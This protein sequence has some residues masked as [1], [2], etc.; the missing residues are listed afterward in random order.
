MLALTPEVP[1]YGVK[2]QDYRLYGLVLLCLGV[3]PL[4]DCPAEVSAVSQGRV[5]EKLA[6][7]AHVFAMFWGA[8]VVHWAWQG[9]E[10]LEE[11]LSERL[12]Q[13]PA[14]LESAP[15]AGSQQEP[16]V[17]IPDDLPAERERVRLQPALTHCQLRVHPCALILVELPRS[18]V[19]V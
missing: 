4:R 12:Q 1:N 6:G 17:V 18:F 7:A 2:L 19:R 10:D 14:P 11:V 8:D 13:L 3:L 9:C 5:D 16:P 15:S